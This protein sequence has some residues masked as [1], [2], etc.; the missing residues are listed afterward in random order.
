VPAALCPIGAGAATETVAALP[1]A[2]RPGRPRPLYLLGPF[3]GLRAQ[4]ERTAGRLPVGDQY[5][6][7]TE[8]EW[9]CCCR[10][11]T[12]TEWNVGSSLKCGRASFSL[13]LGSYCVGATTG[14]GSY[15]PNAWG[16][17]D[18]HG[19]VIEWCLDSWD[20]TANYPSV[21]VSDSYRSSGPYRV[22]RGGS[23]GIFPLHCRSAARG[24]G[25]PGSR[26]DHLG[27]RVVLAPV[28][29]P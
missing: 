15:G 24:R 23:W 4:S 6:L 29:V 11:G 26:V 20:G 14:V 7:P 18:M 19:N 10:A 13:Q 5:R 17:H 12:A 16:L 21:S 25:L 28:L 27:S 1:L 3:P 2:R 9:E 8:A 22:G